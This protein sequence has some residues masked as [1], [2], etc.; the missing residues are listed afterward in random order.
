MREVV[1]EDKSR[2]RNDPAGLEPLNN[3]RVTTAVKSGHLTTR[4]DNAMR[5]G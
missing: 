2:A 4:E 3:S 5:W 1:I